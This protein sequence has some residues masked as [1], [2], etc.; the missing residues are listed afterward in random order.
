M[1]K[2]SDNRPLP[3][4]FG[5]GLDERVVEY[6]W[7]LS[8]LNRQDQ[9]V[10]DA[11]A[12]LNHLW[13]LRRTE[14]SD[15]TVII[16]TLAPESCM[17]RDARFSYIFG[18]LRSTIMCDGAVDASVCISTLEHVGMDNTEFYSRDAKF[19]ENRKEDYLKVMGE[20]YRVT[21]PGGTLFISVPFGREQ[22]HGWFQQ[23]TSPML[24]KLRSYP[25]TTAVELRFYRYTE[26]G[27]NVSTELECK[28]C[29]Y[30][31]FHRHGR[32]RNPDLAAAARAVACLELRKRGA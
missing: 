30:F 17:E 13:L 26:R 1:Q 11:G 20:L 10:L 6:P 19:A 32:I 2:F 31:D 8:R 4:Y 29:E 22:D 24:E 12:T 3:S 15:R 18:D 27:W 23:F 14:F 7:L 21:K 16:Y 28:E 25:D 5:K 9:I